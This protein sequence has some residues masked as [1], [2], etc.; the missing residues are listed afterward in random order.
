MNELGTRYGSSDKGK[1]EWY[2]P[3]IAVKSILPHIR[4]G[5]EFIVRLI[6]IRVNL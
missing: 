1:D 2:T 6:R 5:V 3:E 4:G